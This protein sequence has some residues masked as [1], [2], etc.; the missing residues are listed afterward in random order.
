M[1]Q[2]QDR[3]AVVTGASTGIGKSIAVAYAGEGAKIVLA[4][5]NKVQL[6][7]VAKEIADANGS[8]LVV[9]TDVTVESEVIDLFRQAIDAFGR[10]DILVNNA[11]LSKGGSPDELS[12]DVWQ[13]VIGVNLTGAFICS[14]E[15]LKIMKPQRAGRII[16]I[17]SVSA[18]VPRPHSAPY[19]T[20]KFGLEGLTRSLALDARDFGI[21][22][23]IL[24]PGNT[25]TPIWSGREEI[26]RKE[27]VMSPDDL[28]R[29][30]V[31][32]ATLP[33][34]VNMLE[35]IVLPVSMPFVG[36]G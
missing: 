23:S 4:S 27:G 20:S 31:T 18:K 15:A 35:S 13:Q 25:E 30:A 16:N 12:L 2:L 1:C 26:A 32:I 36:R 11:G 5:R 17:G 29:V 21:A 34:E 24:H 28:A 6:E 3:I 19:T 33:P 8:S 7:T 10:V 14:R 9:P 22:V